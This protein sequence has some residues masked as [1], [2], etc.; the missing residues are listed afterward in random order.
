MPARWMSTA[1]CCRCGTPSW[2]DNLPANVKTAAGTAR[3][4]QPAFRA[5]LC[6]PVRLNSERRFGAALARA[7]MV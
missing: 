1:V 2:D 5:C 4:D 7:G 3:A 6:P